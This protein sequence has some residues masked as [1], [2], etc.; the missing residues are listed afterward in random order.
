MNPDQPLSTCPICLTDKI[1]KVHEGEVLTYETPVPARMILCEKCK[2]LGFPLGNP[3][4]SGQ[5]QGELY[6]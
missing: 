2:A 3:P 5:S 4:N 1:P 6:E